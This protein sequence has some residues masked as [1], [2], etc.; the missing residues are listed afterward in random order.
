MPVGILWV[1]VAAMTYGL[2]AMGSEPGPEIQSRSGWAERARAV[3]QVIAHRGS[4]SDRPECT[5]AALKR[6]IAVKATA[7]EVDVRWT[8]DRHLVILHDSTLDRTT[9]GKGPLAERTLAEVR[10][11]DAGSW[12]DPK[13]RDER[14]PTLREVLEVGRGK[15]DVLLDLKEQ[16]E[17]YDQQVV[18]EV[19]RFGDP[20]RL[21]VGVRSVAQAKRFRRLLPRSRQLGL[22]P[23]PKAIE[24]FVRAG[25]ET[26]RLWPRWV[27]ADSGLVGRVHALNVGLHIN[28]SDGSLKEV[29]AALQHRPTSM[30][31]DDPEQL[32]QSLTRIREDASRL[33]ETRVRNPR[34]AVGH[35]HCEIADAGC[36]AEPGA[37]RLAVCRA[38]FHE[39]G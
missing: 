29:R 33:K 16:G 1:G 32:V 36:G 12:F 34:H 14:V 4:S 20:R 25:V 5:L 30:S 15:I 27:K 8:K 23:N 35:C 38:S 28:G 24:G 7:S 26:I 31:S 11:L 3:K 21:V 18:D 2:L 37:G 6:A 22:V 39:K 10:K 13:F 17:A 19:K 9:N